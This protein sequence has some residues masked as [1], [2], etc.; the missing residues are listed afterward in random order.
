[1]S[2]RV[3][4]LIGFFERFDHIIQPEP[5]TGCWLWLGGTTT[6]RASAGVGYG[7][8]ALGRKVG[9]SRLCYAHRAAYESVH[10]AGS[11]EGLL[12]R[13]SCDMPLCVN[14]GHLSLGT[15]KDN[16]GDM[17]RRGRALNGERNVHAKLTEFQIAEIISLVRSGE[18][19]QRDI[20]RRFGI[21]QSA[22]SF[23]ALGKR[24]AHHIEGRTGFE[25][26]SK[27]EQV[28]MSAIEAT[29][30]GLIAKRVTAGAT[31]PVG[32]RLS[33]LISLLEIEPAD[34]DH[35]RRRKASMARAASE[36]ETLMDADRVGAA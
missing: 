13:H 31:T 21:S 19:L 2:A 36:I 29:R 18:H 22:V 26:P 15:H 9:Q 7:V 16:A 20:A 35:D 24:W 25:T 4:P 10:G 6:G 28:A 32:R 14:P 33:T 1:M 23:I 17:V 3:D 30:R 11:A 5:N 12:V 8:F 34:E 27:K